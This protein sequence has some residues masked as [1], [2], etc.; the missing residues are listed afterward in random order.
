ML[1][2]PTID[3]LRALRLDG[4]AEAFVELQSQDAARDLA[5][6]EWLALL[7]D[8]EAAHRGTQRFKSRLRNAKLRHGQASIE[9]VDYRA[10]RR[11]D[12]ALFQQLAAGRWI[13][14]HRNLLITG[15]CGVGKSWLSCA[16]AQ[17]AC[18]DGYTVHYAR[19]PRL[20]ADLELA[21]GDGRFARLFRTLTKAD[22]LILD[23]W[24]P[25]RLSA[26]QR[27]DLMEIVEDRYGAGSTLIT[28][29]LPVDAWH[30]VIGDPTFADAILDRLVH[31]AHRL[32]LDGPSMR[33]PKTV[34]SD[35]TAL[36]PSAADTTVTKPATGAWI[37]AG[38][39]GIADK[40]Y[41]GSSKAHAKEAADIEAGPVSGWNHHACRLYRRFGRHDGR[42]DRLGRELIA[43]TPIS[44]PS[45]DIATVTVVYPH[46]AEPA[47][48]R[49]L[50]GQAQR[51]LSVGADA[52]GAVR[53]GKCDR[54]NYAGRTRTNANTGEC[55]VRERR[56]RG[57]YVAGEFVEHAR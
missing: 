5:P 10:A 33:D 21:H 35:T 47:R 53:A 57:C 17:R 2:H 32:A 14:E 8:R 36:G 37:V 11:L 51:V 54:G 6:A 24:G 44:G 26:N 22:L 56:S 27:R 46:E 3:Q 43:Q 25:D 40:P 20:F 13:A 12:K 1:T 38:T 30:E 31:N 45:F 42:S 34:K 48:I 18:R 52:R 41:I 49:N 19:V 16:L 50:R 39:A 7:L 28:S 29:Q 9:D 23:D 4:M 55:A 15:P